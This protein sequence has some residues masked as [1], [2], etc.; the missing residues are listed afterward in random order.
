MTEGFSVRRLQVGDLRLY[1]VLRDDMLERHPDAFTSDAQTEARRSAEDYLP[2][3]GL[4]RREG[5]HLTLGAWS[6]RPR[7]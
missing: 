3:L 1:K 4:D 2:R 7:A 5:G 6:S